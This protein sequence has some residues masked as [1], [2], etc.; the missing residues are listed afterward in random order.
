MKGQFLLSWFRRH[1]HTTLFVI[2]AA[3]VLNACGGGEEQSQGGQ[4]QVLVSLTDAE[5]DFVT[6]TVDVLSIKLQKADGTEV[7]VLPMN[8]RVDFAAYTEMTEFL[9]AASVPRGVYTKGSLVLDYSNADIWV[10]DSAGQAVQVTEYLDNNGAPLGT[11]EVNINLEGRGSLPILPGIPKNLLLDFDLKQSNT[12][13][14]GDPISVTVEP[15]I[16]VDIDPQVPRIHR[17]RGPLKSVNVAGNEFEI[18]IRPFFHPIRIGQRVFGDLR[19]VTNDETFYEIDGTTYQG[20]DGLTVLDTMPQFTAVIAVGNVKFA[21]LRFEAT[22]VYAGS[23]VPGGDMDVVRGVVTSRTADDRIIVKGATLLRTDGTVVFNDNVTVQLD[24]S[25]TVIRQLNLGTFD[26]GDI[27]VGQRIVVFGTITNDQVSDLQMSAVNGYARMRLSSAHGS[28]L[29]LPAG[30]GIMTMNVESMNGRNIGIYDFAGTGI[31]TDHDAD[32][33]GYEVDTGMLILDTLMQ[34]D[35]V[36]A[37]G[38]PTPFGSAPADYSA[39][40]IIKP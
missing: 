2:L 26:I 25:T 4:G 7:E 29:A 8:T 1:I 23:S 28:V 10:E 20:T 40:S 16:V 35:V 3:F 9:T 36:S 6:Y 21:P 32:P 22:E 19:V 11:I 12:V 27:S 18:Y 15:V 24:A 34:G 17:T 14:F 30:N 39:Q 37:R 33:A 5:G 38:F 31:D 13:T